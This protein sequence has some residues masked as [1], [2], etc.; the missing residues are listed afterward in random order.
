[1]SE[2]NDPEGRE[3]DEASSEDSEEEGCPPFTVEFEERKVPNIIPSKSEKKRLGKPWQKNPH[4]Q[5]LGRRICYNI[6]K[7]KIDSLWA[8]QRAVQLVDVGN[9]YFLAKFH[10]VKDNDWA[11]TGGPWMV[12]DHYLTI[13]EWEA[14]F[15]PYIAGI[16]KLAAWIRLLGLPMEYYDKKFLKVAGNMIG[17]TL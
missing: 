5:A 11:L 4:Y 3:E 13:R 16:Q 14:G 15:N 9:D 8:R 17:R 6:L 2:N 12:F 1:M 10:S 7:K